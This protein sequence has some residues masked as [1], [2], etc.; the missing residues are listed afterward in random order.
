MVAALLLCSIAELT[1]DCCT[2]RDSL[3]SVLVIASAVTGERF[4][5]SFRSVRCDVLLKDRLLVDDLEDTVSKV[6]SASFAPCKRS[7][8]FDL[9]LCRLH[10]VDVVLAAKTLVV[11]FLA[12]CSDLST[13]H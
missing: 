11:S 9:S 2:F 6:S 10:R 1:C 5:F 3:F 4:P 12:F 13:K 7:T 8:L